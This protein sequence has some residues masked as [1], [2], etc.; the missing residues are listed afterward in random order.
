MTDIL[1]QG[2]AFCLEGYSIFCLC[3]VT[4]VVNGRVVELPSVRGTVCDR[5]RLK[6]QVFPLWKVEKGD[7]REPSSAEQRRH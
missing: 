2:N 3:A 6:R 1:R 7:Y 5:L 4:Q